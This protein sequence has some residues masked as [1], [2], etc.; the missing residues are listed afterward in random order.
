MAYKA[1]QFL[2]TSF[3]ELIL[4]FDDVLCI[5]EIRR[6]QM[7]QKGETQMTVYV[8]QQSRCEIVLRHDG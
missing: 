1:T 4:G 3:G 7:S 2:L 5:K 8:F 6:R